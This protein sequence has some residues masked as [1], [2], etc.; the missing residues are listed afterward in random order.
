MKKQR[1]IRKGEELGTYG[2]AKVPERGIERNIQQG[3]RRKMQKG[4]RK[5]ERKKRGRKTNSSTHAIER[6]P[7]ERLILRLSEMQSLIHLN[8]AFTQCPSLV[9]GMSAQSSMVRVSDRQ[10]C[11]REYGEQREKHGWCMWVGGWGWRKM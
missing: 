6:A 10:S 3:R 11:E 4:N 7:L 5:K 9:R 2:E 1:I 8:G